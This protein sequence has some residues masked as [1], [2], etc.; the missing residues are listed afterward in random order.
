M[1]KVTLLI[2]LMLT[3][4]SWAGP[5]PGSADEIEFQTGLH[6][7]W[8]K[9]SFGDSGD[10]I[11]IPVTVGA[12]YKDFALR[13]IGGQAWTWFDP[14]Q[15]KETSLAHILDTKLGLSYEIVDKLP[16]DVMLG[17]DFNLPTGKTNIRRND[18]NIMMDP[19][20]VTVIRFGEGFNVNP[21]LT[22]TK[23]WGEKWVT[24]IG[25]GYAFRGEYDFTLDKKNFQPGDIFSIVPEVRYF[26]SDGWCA[27]LFGNY[28]HFGEDKVTN[29]LFTFLNSD[30]FFRQGD[31]YLGG[32]GVDY[33]Q[34]RW[35]AG[36]TFTGIY[37]DKNE[38]EN[39]SGA[40]TTQGSQAQGEEYIADL[41]FQYLL[42]DRLTF[43]SLLHMIWIIEQTR[44]FQERP[45]LIGDREIYSLQVG[46][47]AKLT[48]HIE[49]EFNIRGFG[50]PATKSSL[51]PIQDA[52][53]TG[54]ATEVK[55]T[56]TF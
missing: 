21:T 23:Q 50:I 27:R 38:F 42:T 54:L 37:R 5:M 20:L 46:L 22:L 10:Q 15:G 35:R 30:R 28:S 7:D 56:G 11:L 3:V 51:H 39:F 34:P 53:F 9:N 48:P 32:I 17:L 13:I 41:S 25:F 14:A 49:G 6:F 24:G 2:L 52:S 12:R 40:L 29:G 19:D 18:Q 55:L 44:R 45:F 26:F 31:F 33:K 43:K 4:L 1:K 47:S 8:W 16:V 36:F